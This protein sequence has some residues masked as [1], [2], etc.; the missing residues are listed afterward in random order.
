MQGFQ[1]PSLFFSL[2]VDITMAVFVI[3]A[4]T[5]EGWDFLFEKYRSSLQISVKSRL[6]SAMA[7]SPLQD[8]LKWC[9]YYVK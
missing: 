7:V 1:N 6:K 4:R 5:P 2:P 9:V 3:G 8:K